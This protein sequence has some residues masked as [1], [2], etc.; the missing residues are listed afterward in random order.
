[1]TRLALSTGLCGSLCLLLSLGAGGCTVGAGTGT[2]EGPLWILGCQNDQ[3]FGDQT[4]PKDFNL[5]P[6]FFAGDPIEDISQGAHTNRLRV[7]MQRLGRGQEDDDTLKF[8]FE[9]SYE[10]ARCVRGRVDS[11]TGMNDWE[12]SLTNTMNGHLADMPA[13]DVPWCDWSAA[14]TDADA[15][16][17]IDAGVSAPG[18][19]PRLHF[20]SEGYTKAWLNPASTCPLARLVGIG[21][22]GWIEVLD[23]GSAGQPDKPPEMRDPVTSDFKVE[24]GERLRANFHIELEDDKVRTAEENAEP[25]PASRLGG[26]IDGYF[27]FQLERGRALQPFP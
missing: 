12:Q 14:T 2:A 24:F 19:H 1:M 27:D 13:D 22:S 18:P 10:I 17:S 4:N 26:T 15:G 23:F 16:M 25:V 20:S 6:T 21:R 3:N 11:S 7:R 9:N 5:K 8:D